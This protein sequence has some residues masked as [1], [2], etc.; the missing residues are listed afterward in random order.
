MHVNSSVIK[1]GKFS[2]FLSRK[3]RISEPFLAK[4]SVFQ[5]HRQLF[6]FGGKRGQLRAQLLGQGRQPM[7]LGSRDI[8]AQLLLGVRNRT[9]DARNLFFQKRA[10]LLHLLLL[11]RIQPPRAVL[12]SFGIGIRGAVAPI[13]VRRRNGL[14]LSSLWRHLN[15]K[16]AG[17]NP[18]RRLPPPAPA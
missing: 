4:S 8:N 6:P 11:D 17:C 16:A 5:L 13:A 2:P 9:L 1:H 15:P 18:L 10:P 14:R 7:R 3:C 12:H